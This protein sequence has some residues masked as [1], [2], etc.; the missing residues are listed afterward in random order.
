[1]QSI[2]RVA[3]GLIA[4]AVLATGCSQKALDG[5]S[6]KMERNKKLPPVFQSGIF[7]EYENFKA[8]AAALG[9]PS[10]LAGSSRPRRLFATRI[11]VD[12]SSQR[13]WVVKPGQRAFSYS[14]S[15]SRYGIGSAVGSLKTPLGMHRV[16]S[17]F[18][19]GLPSGAILKGR[20]STGEIAEIL[21]A[22]GSRS[23]ADLITTRVLWL[24]GLEEGKNRGGGVDSFA[25]YIYIHGTDEEGLIGR[26]AS[27][28]CIRMRNSEVID[29]FDRVEEG[30]L[31]Y[32]QL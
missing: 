11:L 14:I 15:T 21:T 13:L 8:P 10:K 12:V 16:K 31:V 1:M 3:P 32:I 29:L 25:R 22:P 26:P 5:R 27:D 7:A 2:G 4:L 17:K 24:E 30:A 6:L 18:G 28:G 9:E 23:E 19:Q 20:R